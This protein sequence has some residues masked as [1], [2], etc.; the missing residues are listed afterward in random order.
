MHSMEFSLYKKAGAS[1]KGAP[2]F[3]FA[4]CLKFTA[5]R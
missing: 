4:L 2:V 5:A 1:V 3:Y